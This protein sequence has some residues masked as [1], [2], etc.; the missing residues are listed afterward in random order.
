MF[1]VSN[2]LQ[3]VSSL[4]WDVYKLIVLFH[5]IFC[6]SFSSS[7]RSR[8]LWR[9]FHSYLSP[10][11]STYVFGAAG[12]VSWAQTYQ[13]F[14][15][16]EVWEARGIR[17]GTKTSLFW[18]RPEKTVLMSY[19]FHST[20]SPS[21]PIFKCQFDLT[22]QAKTRSIDSAFHYLLQPIFWWLGHFRLCELRGPDHWFK[23]VQCHP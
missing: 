22:F 5:I 16:E 15:T 20:A 19:A 17:P 13:G 10:W 3:R 4:L 6:P 11:F 8:H 2:T 21:Q 7:W 18:G 23:L 1:P 9:A 12:K 14:F